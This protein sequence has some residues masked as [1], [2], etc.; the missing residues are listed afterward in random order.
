MDLNTDRVAPE[1]NHPV[2]DINAVTI[3][4]SITDAFVFLDSQWRCRYVNEPACVLLSKNKQELF[5]NCIWE[6]FP[7][8]GGTAFE[9]GLLSSERD[10]KMVEVEAWCS[11]H[12]RWYLCRSYPMS[13]GVSVY[14]NDITQRRLSDERIQQAESR[15]RDLYENAPDMFCSV[16]AITG[17]IIQCNNTLSRETGYSKEEI[18]GRPVFEICHP[19]CL[20]KVHTAFEQFVN[21]GVV[22]DVELQFQRKDG[23]RMDVM[24]NVTATRDAEGKILY[25]RSI[26]RNI[27]EY[28]RLEAERREL[29]IQNR[30]QQVQRLESLGVLAGGI[31]HDF[32][33]ILTAV[34]GNI[35]LAEMKLPPG[36]PARTH[37]E[38]ATLSARKAA[39][40]TSQMLAYSGKGHF[41][42]SKL[43]LSQMVE[44]MSS[45]LH[46]SISQ[47]ISLDFA[48]SSSLPDIR[49]DATQIHQMIQNLVVNA[50]EAIEGNVGK[51]CITTASVEVTSSMQIETTPHQC[52][53]AGPYVF[54]E[55]SDT[56]CGMSSELQT[57][58]FDPFF[59][60]KFPGR[61]LGL[62]VVQGIVLGHQG[63]IQ[64]E[65]NPGEGATFRIL[66]PVAVCADSVSNSVPTH[67][68]AQAGER[69]ILV[70]DDEAF[71][72]KFAKQAL[73]LMGYSVLTAMH[74]T[75]AVEVFR[76]Y[77]SRIDAVVLNF[78]IPELNGVEA[79]LELQ[80]LQQEVK[81]IICSGHDEQTT[82]ELF[83]GKEV[84]AY[85]TKPFLF[86]DLR[87]VVTQVVGGPSN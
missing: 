6:L 3:L 78:S 49:G 38:E 74:G 43:D 25:S 68:Q 17:K 86:D 13:G 41:V 9:E 79:L 55:V 37:L 54:L 26:I 12:Q 42:M 67:D 34:L 53:S 46:N 73:E 40:L 10:Q 47:K 69:F 5:G 16:D 57:K 44:E 32:S 20:P 64:V 23:S 36:S 85:L 83:K 82:R 14:F 70:V 31:A 7:E 81:V 15:Y 50:A 52:L 29:E 75:D 87:K 59:T 62:S 80:K 77:N 8:L 18:I 71:V 72:L 60:T 11:L 22:R 45:L 33:N 2:P 27:S 58:I 39:K 66:F 76:E 1:T 30:V 28:K 61:G 4:E 65:S 19:E 84:A 24:L 56:G 63:A 48:I 51:I 35:S 21:T